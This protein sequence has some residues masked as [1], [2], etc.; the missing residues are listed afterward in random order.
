M[1]IRRGE[2]DIAE[3]EAEIAEVKERIQDLR[4]RP[5]AVIDKQLAEE[6]GEGETEE[7]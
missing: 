1:E 6:F 4:I 2:S 5:E 3:L 7:D